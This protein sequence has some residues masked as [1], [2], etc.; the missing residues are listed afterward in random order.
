MIDIEY[1]QAISDSFQQSVARKQ[2]IMKVSPE[3]D[4]DGEITS[5]LALDTRILSIATFCLQENIQKF[6]EGLI[7]SGQ[8]IVSLFE[9][10]AAG[11]KID[12]SYIGISRFSKVLEALAAG[13]MALAKCIAEKLQML[14]KNE[15]HSPS[16]LFANAIIELI[17]GNQAKVRDW[18]EK[19]AKTTNEY[20][21]GYAQMLLAII[22]DT[23][24]LFEQGLKTVC[25]KHKIEVEKANLLYGV[26]EY[27]CIWGLG[28]MNYARRNGLSVHSNNSLIPT[29]LLTQV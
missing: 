28:L 29:E 2:M 7:T 23:P 12:E 13:D 3:R 5:D 6:Q 17:L 19:L 25:S 16:D 15:G 4:E 14:P 18:S 21:R 9:R 22:D 1:L 11:E 8:L 24:A 26:D 27:I 20:Y 10:Y